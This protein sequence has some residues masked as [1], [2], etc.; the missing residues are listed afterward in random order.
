MTTAN[1]HLQSSL[2]HSESSLQG[3][4]DENLRL[5]SALNQMAHANQSFSELSSSP[6]ALSSPSDPSV[7][8]LRS[9]LIAC[10]RQ[11]DELEVCLQ[12]ILQDLEERTPLVTEL[13][14]DYDTL[15]QNYER[16]MR[17]WRERLT[18]T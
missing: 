10:R 2:Q 16:V 11:K 14:K 17:V 15:R 18:Y 4:R 13:K 1:K 9:E 3:I 8:S 12:A 6:A 7:S 5:I